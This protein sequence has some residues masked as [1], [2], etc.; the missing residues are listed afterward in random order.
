MPWHAMA[1]VLLAAASMSAILLIWRRRASVLDLW[2]RVAMIAW[3]IEVLLEAL[4]QDGMSFAWHLAQLYT[5]L[6]AACVTMALL[7]ENANLYS[8]LA[9]ALSARDRLREGFRASRRNAAEA[10]IDA[11]ADELNQPLCAIT[12]N[13]D[14]ITRLLDREP[15]DMRGDSRGAG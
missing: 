8:R 11:I 10:A 6:G 5:V 12:A 2:L 4:A 3:L 9:G 7:A 14:A 15:P 13:V 1:T